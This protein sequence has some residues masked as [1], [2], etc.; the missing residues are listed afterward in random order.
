MAARSIEV[1]F[2]DNVYKLVRIER[3]SSDGYLGAESGPNVADQEMTG[4][5]AK[6]RLCTRMS[7]S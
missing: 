5:V 4:W 2:E 6:G 3:R 7:H 1:A